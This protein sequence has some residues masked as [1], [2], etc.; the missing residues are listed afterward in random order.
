[1]ARPDSASHI[2][3]ALALPGSDLADRDMIMIL[4]AFFSELAEHWTI[5]QCGR[6]PV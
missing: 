2:E 6:M 3:L 5:A 1:M 4:A